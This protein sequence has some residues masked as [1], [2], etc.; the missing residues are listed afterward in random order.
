MNG[1]ITPDM[2]TTR[3]S[4]LALRFAATLFSP[5]STCAEPL[6]TEFMAAN[7]ATLLDEDGQ[8]ADWIE[9]YN[10]DVRPLDLAGWHLTDAAKKKTKWTFPAVILPPQG[11]LVVF[12]SGKDRREPSRQLHTNFSLDAAGEYLA[13]VR[14]DGEGLASEFAPYPAQQSDVSFGPD[15]F[16]REP[17]PGA[18]NA[19]ALLPQTVAFSRAS[20]VFAGRVTVELQGAAAGQH[21]RYLITSERPETPAAPPAALSATATPYTGPIT[22]DTSAVVTAAVFS[23]DTTASGRPASACFIRLHPN[24]QGFASRLPVLVLDAP[25]AAPWTRDG[26]D[27]ASWLFEYEAAAADAPSFAGP[28]RL[29]S[30]ATAG[31]RGAS[32]AD[33]PKKGYNLR[34]CD[35]HGTSRP[36]SLAGLPAAARWALVAPWLYDPTYVHNA[37]VYDLSNRLGRW[38]P[39]TRLVEVY[40]HADGGDLTPSDYAGVYVVTERIEPGDARVDLAPPGAGDASGRDLTGGYILKIDAPDA[41]DHAWQTTRGVSPQRESS[42]ILVSPSAADATA[43]QRDY[44]AGYVQRLENALAASLASQ[45]RQRTYLDYLDRASWV[46]HHL[47]NTFVANPDAFVRSAYFTKDRGEKMRAG[48]VWDFDRALGSAPD[49]RSL[50]WFEWSS[51][52]GVDHW[53]TGWWGLLAQDPEFRQDWIDRWQSLRQTELSDAALTARLGACAETVGSA[54]A[55]RDATRW[56]ENLS[57]LGSYAAQIAETQS[58]LTQRAQWIDRQFVPAPVTTRDGERLTFTA[59]DGAQLAYTLDGTDPRSIGGTLAPNARLAAAELT[60]AASANAHVRAYRA[61]WRAIFPGTPWSSLAR[62]PAASP[63][64]PASRLAQISV[65]AALGSTREAVTLGVA[66][67]D[68]EAKPYLFR[69]LGPGLAA[70]GVESAV[71]APALTLF[72]QFGA[73][74]ARNDGW[75]TGPGAGALPPAFAALGALPLAGG[76]RD[77]AISAELPAGTYSLRGDTTDGRAGTALLELYERDDTGRTANVSVQIQVAGGQAVTGGFVIQGLARKRVLLR[78]AGP[79]L[80]LFGISHPLPDPA[81]EIFAGAQ[82]IASSDEPA[83]GE[84]IARVAQAGAAAGA[85]AFPIGGSD[86]GVLLTLAPGAYTFAVRSR[87]GQSGA[88]LLELYDLP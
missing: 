84:T 46:D 76:S 7:S 69:A 79:A 54:A 86:P 9:I 11:Y 27:H 1:G 37:W 58:W 60:V 68:T 59:A 36:Q 32:S 39:R 51:P 38:A 80:R 28:P 62:S 24:L 30:P 65:R 33:F 19:S 85:F 56:P 88:V 5:L 23:D 75:D 72:D 47:I 49:A 53:R 73:E 20:G 81:L 22:L 57:R 66:V 43:A 71:N 6:I 16:H 83:D 52:A 10:P 77:A 18:A 2:K 42:V 34:L 44:I 74:V 50:A 13:L 41:D 3:L 67:A 12:A 14:P 82:R 21:I 78:A 70:L 15:G 87:S 29:A 55:A 40:L 17:T 26:R 64:A 61:D 48:P 63:L 31:V 25:G 4:S 8:A 45:W 35:E